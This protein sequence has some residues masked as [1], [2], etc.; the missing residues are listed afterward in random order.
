MGISI[1]VATGD[2]GTLATGSCAAS[3]LGTSTIQNP[4]NC[5]YITGVG[6]AQILVNNTETAVQSDDW[7]IDG[8]FSNIYAAPDY[9]AEA[10]GAY[11]ANYTPTWLEGRYNA[12]GRGVPDLSAVGLNIANAV[13]GELTLQA[14][15]S[16]A[17]PLFTAMLNLVN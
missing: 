1:L 8:G 12:S 2:Y 5:P 10:L 16:A 3:N 6:A 11:F 7:T 9:Q 4:V 13:G 17:T 15:T 14:S